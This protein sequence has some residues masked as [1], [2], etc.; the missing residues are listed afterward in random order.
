LENTPRPL[1]VEVRLD[2]EVIL[3]GQMVQ[4]L[5]DFAEAESGPVKERL[6]QVADVFGDM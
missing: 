2:V 4:I 6:N 5:R 3:R 1:K